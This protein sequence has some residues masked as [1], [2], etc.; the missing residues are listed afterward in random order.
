MD[1]L[2]VLLQDGCQ[3]SWKLVP[4]PARMKAILSEQHDDPSAGHPGIVKTFKKTSAY[5]F[6]PGMYQDI[7]NYVRSCEVCQITKPSNEKPAG[8]MCIKKINRIGE[9]FYADF[10]GPYPVSSSLNK[11]ILVLQDEFSKYVEMVAVRTATAKTVVQ[12]FKRLVIFRYGVPKKLI[13]DNGSHFANQFVAQMAEEYGFAHV[14][15]PPYSPHINICERTNRITK[16]MIKA[17]LDEKQMKWDQYLPEF[18][19]AI[20][21]SPQ[22]TTGYSPNLLMFGREIEPVRHT[23][24]EVE[25]PEESDDEMLDVEY[26]S[27]VRS[28]AAI[29]ELRELVTRNKLKASAKQAHYYNQRRNVSVTYSLGEKCWRKNFR[30]SKGDSHYNAALD[31]KFLGPFIIVGQVSPVIFTLQDLDG[32]L[33]GN[34]HVKDLRKH[35]ERNPGATQGVNPNDSVCAITVCEE[36]PGTSKV[37]NVQ[38]G[39]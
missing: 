6:W 30:L 34:Y 37:G 26:P 39:R 5:Y 36:C 21:S 3:R 20:N 1:Q 29:E 12:H 35:V 8:K 33:E 32:N 14:K 10:M 9:I 31:R 28:Q 25:P 38:V 24:R 23:R 18:Q 17:Y 19:F 15:I 13:T 16:A 4:E 27:L 11:Y 22:T 2:D 7:A